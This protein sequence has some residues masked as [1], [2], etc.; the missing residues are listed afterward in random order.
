MHGLVIHGGAGVVLSRMTQQQHARFEASLSGILDAGFEILSRGGTSLDA[1]TTAVRLL[2]DDPLFNAGQGAALACDGAVELD[3]AIMD[4]RNQS[5]GAVACVKHVRN[6]VELAR[7]V[8]E[9]SRHVM[10]VGIGA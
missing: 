4:G 2:E 9:K 3:A 6:P 8:M 5:A 1:V 7:R 10:L